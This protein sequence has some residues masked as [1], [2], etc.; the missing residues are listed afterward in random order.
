MP[1]GKE[2]STELPAAWAERCAVGWVHACPAK[3]RGWLGGVGNAGARHAAVFGGLW[4]KSECQEL[5]RL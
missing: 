3:R 1:A 4:Y 2:D 5:P